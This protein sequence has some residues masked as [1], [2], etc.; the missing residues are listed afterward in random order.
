MKE[1]K[2]PLQ[3]RIASFFTGVTGLLTATAAL[4]GAVVGILTATG[5]IGGGSNGGASETHAASRA[6]MGD[7][8]IL[9]VRRTE[10]SKVESGKVESG[11]VE[12]EK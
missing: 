7:D 5:V 11:K 3:Q 10:G 6:R 1:P 12:S 2:Q 8:G 4:I 9:R